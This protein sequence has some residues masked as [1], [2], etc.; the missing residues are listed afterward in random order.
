MR[1]LLSAV[2]SAPVELPPWDRRRAC[3]RGLRRSWAI[4]LAAVLSL[5]AGAARAQCGMC[6]GTSSLNV[7]RCG[8]AETVCRMV[9]INTPDPSNPAECDSGCSFVNCRV[10]EV[11]GPTIVPVPTPDGKITA[12]LTMDVRSVWNAV[13]GDS[14]SGSRYYNPNGTLDMIWYESE[15]VPSLCDPPVPA[16]QCDWFDTDHATCYLEVTGLTCTGAPYDFGVVSFRAQT[17]GGPEALC[18]F[19]NR[20][21]RAADFPGL[22]FMVTKQDLGCPIP[23]TEACNGD[24]TASCEE[25]LAGGVGVGG[26]GPGAGGSGGA[27][28]PAPGGGAYLY[29]AAGG[30]GHAGL[31]GSVAWNA[32]LGRHWSHSYAER[33]VADPDESHV[34]LITR[35]ATFREWSAPD[36]VSGVYQTVSPSNEVRTLTWTGAGWTL[37]ELDGT[38]HAFDGGGLWF[39]TTD[40]NGNAKTAVYSGGVLT[41]VH[42]PDGRREDFTYYPV[43]DPSEGKLATITE[44]GVDLS[45][46][47]IWSYSWSG[48]DLARVD[49][50]DGTAI[51]YTYGDG[52]FPGYLTRIELEGT[53]GTSTRVERAY[54]YDDAGNVVASWAGDAVKTGPAAVDLWQLSFDDPAEPATTTVTDPLGQVITYQLGRDT[55]SSN[56][57]VVSISGDCPVCGL[58]PN[59]TLAY[60]DPAH[61]LLPTS[62]T[63]GRGHTTAMSYDAYGQLT[64]RTEA[65]GEPE[66]RTTTWSHDATYPGL[67]TSIETPSVV[68]GAS[69]RTTEFLREDGPHNST[70]VRITGVEAGS[71][72][73]YD[74]VTDFNGAGEPLTVDPPGHAAADQTI[75]SYTPPAPGDPDRGG[76]FPF[77]RTDPL[78]GDTT[79]DYDPFNRRTSVL[80]PN[81]VETATAY[82]GL[83]RV[84]EVRQVGASPPADDL[85]TTSE[86]T[87]FGDLF[88]TILPEGN[89]L[90]YG[91]D[92]AG[93]LVS[94]ERKPDA[95]PESH[96]ER[97]L[98]T[99]DEAGNRTLE[100]LQRWD[101]DAAAWVTLSATEYRYANRCQVD[102]VIQ[103]PGMPEEAVT[104]YAYDCNGNLSQVWDPNH[105]RLDSV[106]QAELPETALY[107]YDAVDRLTSVTQP[108]GGG[109]GGFTVTSYA[110]DVQDHL[111]GV[112]DAEGNITTYTYSDRDLLTHEL[113][114]AFVDPLA[115][116]NPAPAC[117]PGCGC[118]AH[119]YDEHGALDATLDARGVLVDRTVDAL[120]RV[121]SVDY[122]GT[123]LDVLYSYDTEPAVCAGS[124]FEV[125]RLGSITRN[126]QAVELCYDRFGRLTR[127]GALVYGYDKNGNRSTIAYPGGVN[128]T[129][130]YDFADRPMSLSVT[131]PGGTEPVVTAASY[132]PSGP[133]SG[134]V[135][136]SGTTETR[137]FD[138]RYAPT[139]I[140]V[141]GDPSVP[142]ASGGIGDHAWSYTT[143]RI[144]S[145]LEIVERAACLTEP[146]VLASQTVITTETYTS[147]SDLQAGGGF[148]VQGPG[149]VTFEAQGSV[150]LGTGFSVGTGARFAAGSGGGPG[151]SHRTYS[152]Q[153]V[154]YYLTGASGPWPDDLAWTYDR[155]GNRRTESRDG[156]ATMDG[157]LYTANGVAGN[158]PILDQITLAVGG[159]RDYTWGAA[160]HL[161]EVGT[162]G[163]NPVDLSW[164]AAGRLASA[165]RSAAGA[166]SAFAYDGRSYLTRA[167]QTAG[168]TALV[169][170]VYDSSGV[171]HVLER[172]TSPSDPIER[173]VHLY[174][175]GRPVA[176]LT[177]DGTG[178]ETWTYLTTDHLGT[179]LLAT[180]AAGAVVWDGGF[181]PFGRDYQE[182]L[183]TGALQNGIALRLPG[184]WDDQTWTDATSGAGVYYNVYRWYQPGVGRY[185]RVDPIQGELRVPGGASE[186][187][188][189]LGFLSILAKN[190]F[191]YA[192]ANPLIR[193]DPLGLVGCDGNWTVYTWWRLGDPP[194]VDPA[195]LSSGRRGNQLPL[196]NR[197]P[198]A[199]GPNPVRSPRGGAFQLLPPGVCYC[200]WNCIP[201]EGGFMYDPRNLP[202]TKGLTVNTG[203]DI[204]SGDTCLCPKPGLETGCGD[205]YICKPPPVWVPRFTLE[206][207]L[208]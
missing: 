186:G 44:V 88:Q 57:K 36:P 29:Y 52:R 161:E 83:D 15:T 39:S 12:R 156:G 199:R 90:E 194:S 80:D 188:A 60:D 147:C 63:D 89:V 127:D 54:E 191:A 190:P 56:T 109:G 162:G 78:V 184:Q 125:G 64:S 133:L 34:W 137:T 205:Q 59:T 74:T 111:V 207:P 122:P 38:V 167:E 84:T 141:S 28:N 201:C 206:W 121:T 203:R 119:T 170:P 8:V 130:G 129:Y 53:D 75:W 116:C 42:F 185:T 107:L 126:G 198:N 85:V 189:G 179:P 160:G 9:G 150:I 139:G 202:I 153:D 72:F 157:Y 19:P 62:T 17:C 27:G 96:G 37:E 5:G 195:P 135:L 94:V 182:G 50:P 142:A 51:V 81:G 70:T 149:D 100:E 35:Y 118:T 41:Q 112:T 159:T 95:L 67:V 76:L 86:H 124:S 32:T 138:G 196:A 143:D 200:R 98:Y 158:T 144:G 128:A 13:A 114:D 165:N 180:D 175:A 22:S 2:L 43:G 1:K 204:T 46:S 55:V 166:S 101:A 192:R 11:T 79:F 136:G 6:S 168:G 69:L 10:P 65:M 106:T 21:G 40:R 104:E 18:G 68:G 71:A 197:I 169:V 49:R 120:D 151:L 187:I 110:Y 24:S 93:R 105:P 7:F 134:L 123:A 102:Q 172:Q 77:T 91:Y 183:P 31:P 25:C 208:P 48:D 99:L 146:V 23:P 178:T 66:E 174:L 87:V 113:V 20:C 132:L 115:T 14:S 97:T 177:I 173:T 163:A 58:G 131:S 16:T 61:P 176:Q 193:V 33:I 164:D 145:I 117:D 47:R 45:T 3:P 181:E 103:S 140:G 92:P 171:L 4:V 108:W 155:I 154:Q 30:A 26:G 82:D 73:T 148:S 152:Y